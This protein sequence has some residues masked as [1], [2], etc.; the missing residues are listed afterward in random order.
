M[1][2]KVAVVAGATGLV[3]RELV[4]QLCGS[5]SYSAVVA[6]VRDT[7]KV[8]SFP[9][10]EK[11]SIRTFPTGGDTIVADECYCALGTTRKKAGSKSNFIAVDHDLV[12]DLAKRAKAGGV[13][14]FVVITSVGSDAGS[15][16]FYLRVKGQTEKDLLSLNL[17]GLEI[18]RPSLLLGSRLEWRPLERL[19]VVFAPL[20]SWLLS[21]RLSK[22]RPIAASELARRMIAGVPLGN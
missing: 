14:R 1:N 20:L 19:G 16:N 12:L 21:G 6:L 18:Y 5:E 8:A 2:G 3:G 15:G 22:Y 10:S 13:A 7:R 9:Q 4:R 11:L 17:R